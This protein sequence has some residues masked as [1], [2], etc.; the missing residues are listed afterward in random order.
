MHPWKSASSVLFPC[1]LAP[2]QCLPRQPK[3]PAGS[4]HCWHFLPCTKTCHFTADQVGSGAIP[5]SDWGR[6]VTHNFSHEVL[7]AF[8]FTTLGHTCHSAVS[9]I[10]ALMS[11]WVWDY[12]RQHHNPS[13]S[14]IENKVGNTPYLMVSS[15]G[16]SFSSSQISISTMYFITEGNTLL[17][18]SIISSFNWHSEFCKTWD[19]INMEKNLKK[20][21]WGLI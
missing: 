9:G 19:N 6:T 7:K 12:F 1:P 20:I 3:A 18:R 8:L 10:S 17:E 4:L 2:H 14:W 11:A 16:S 15:T 13:C 5:F 21:K